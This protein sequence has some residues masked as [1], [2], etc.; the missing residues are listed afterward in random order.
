MAR[1]ASERVAILPSDGRGSRSR[2]ALPNGWRASFR[3]VPRCSA[4][5]RVVPRR[6]APLRA[7]PPRSAS[8]RLA[9]PR[10]AL[11]RLAPPRSASLRLAPSRSASPRV[12]PPAR[13]LL[14]S[15]ASAQHLSANGWFAGAA[16]QQRKHT[17]HRVACCEAP[18]CFVNGPTCSIR[19]SRAPKRQRQ[20]RFPFWPWIGKQQFG[21][22]WMSGPEHRQ[23]QSSGVVIKK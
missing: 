20:T 12:T 11:L 1:S 16:A 23:N 3:V 19:H 18:G 6:S 22:L 4:L 13:H 9:P 15:Q 2:G 7:A 21:C 10:S 5:F 17:H 8:L 14:A